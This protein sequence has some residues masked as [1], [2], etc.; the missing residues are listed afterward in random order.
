MRTRIEGNI[1]GA[2]ELTVRTNGQTTKVQ[3]T[4]Y[5]VRSTKEVKERTEPRASGKGASAEVA[6][7]LRPWTGQPT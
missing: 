7:L 3:F 1:Q 5:V 4:L 6:S 2:K